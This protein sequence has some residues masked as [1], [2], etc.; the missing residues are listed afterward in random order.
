M[1]KPKPTPLAVS[2]AVT[3]ALQIAISVKRD[4]KSVYK[5]KAR[6][7]NTLR[8]RLT[9]STQQAAMRAVEGYFS[10]QSQQAA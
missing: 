6:V 9:E 4:G 2:D 3:Q 5:A 8:G 1:R 10:E 7:L